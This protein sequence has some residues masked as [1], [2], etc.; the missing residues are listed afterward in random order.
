MPHVVMVVPRMVLM[1]R[2]SECG[3]G[4]NQSHAGRY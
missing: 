4:H 1:R 3:I 2:L